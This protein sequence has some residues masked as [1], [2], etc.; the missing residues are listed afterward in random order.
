MLFSHFILKKK[1]KRV[2]WENEIKNQTI[3]NENNEITIDPIYDDVDV[4]EIN[5]IYR[6]QRINKIYIY[7]G[8]VGTVLI[9]MI[10]RNYMFVVMCLRASKRLHNRLF[11]GITQAK[12]SFFGTN[13]SGLIINRF[14]KDM[15]IIDIYIPFS[16]H[17]T[18]N[19][20]KMILFS[21]FSIFHFSFLINKHQMLFNSVF[22][23]LFL[24]TF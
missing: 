3:I 20:C 8:I 17:Y 16:L 4:D 2:T 11:T 6:E 22:I 10:T 18:I 12:M 1:K 5:N 21:L 19:V 14:A 23:Y 15:G 13:A 9:L 7:C 24:L